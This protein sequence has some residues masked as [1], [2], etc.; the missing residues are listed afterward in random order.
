[1]EPAQ[2]SDRGAEAADESGRPRRRRQRSLPHGC[3]SGQRR[4]GRRARVAAEGISAGSQVTEAATEKEELRSRT[5][6]PSHWLYCLNSPTSTFFQKSC[7]A[8]RSAG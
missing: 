6:G 8:S 2:G 3:E 4:E 5:E 7:G 1:S